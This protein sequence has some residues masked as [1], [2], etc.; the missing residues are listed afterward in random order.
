VGEGGSDVPHREI[1][2]DIVP[3]RLGWLLVAATPRGVCHARFGEAE[4]ELEG[5]VQAEFVFAAP[6]RDPVALKPWC[7][8]LVASIEGHGRALDLPLDVSGSRFQRRVWDALRRIPRGETRSYSAVAREVGVPAGARA[9]ARACA[10]N[11]VTVAIP[12]HRVVRSDGGLGGYRW[13]VE[14]KRALLASEADSG[15]GPQRSG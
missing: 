6:R 10:A 4:A 11:P 9:V 14:R 5:A 13:G 15:A 3:C 7:D 12:C 2:Y 1:V 8:R